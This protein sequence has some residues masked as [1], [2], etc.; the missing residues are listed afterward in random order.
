MKLIYVALLV[1]C[2][3]CEIKLSGIAQNVALAPE[4]K[5]NQ[6]NTLKFNTLVGNI[7]SSLK[8]CPTNKNLA[9][10][11]RER[12]PRFRLVVL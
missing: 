10:S 2:Y 12:I 8:L 5:I 4:V 1:G 9:T 6:F 11:A 3:I 7:V